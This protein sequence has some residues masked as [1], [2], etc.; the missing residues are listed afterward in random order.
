[1]ALGAQSGEKK[2]M[3][4]KNSLSPSK[5][6]G[7]KQVVP[8]EKQASFF[9]FGALKQEVDKLL[10][11]FPPTGVKKKH[12]AETCDVPAAAAAA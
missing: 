10:L 6:E 12:N 7:K 2:K 3:N 8:P 9:I 1:M 11:F 4:L 5:N